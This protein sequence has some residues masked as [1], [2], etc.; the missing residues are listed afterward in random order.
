MKELALQRI[1]LGGSCHWCTEAIFRSL[2]GV[3]RVS[4]GWLS[5]AGDNCFSEG[6]VIE[7]DEQVID[8]QTV[9]EIHLHTHS[10]TSMHALRERYRSAVY[11]FEPAQKQAAQECLTTLQQEFEQPLITR[12]L[13]YQ[14]FEPSRVQIQDYYYSNPQKPFCINQITPKLQKLLET[15]SCRVEPGKRAVIEDG[16]KQKGRT[17]MAEEKDYT[18][19]HDREKHEYR[20]EV[21]PGVYA[22]VTYRE[23]DNVLHLTY[24][25][26]PSSMRGQGIGSILMD[27]VLSQ[28]QSE[29]YRVLPVCGFISNYIAEH[30]KWH[31]LLAD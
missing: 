27:K 29:G 23:E 16:I 2:N 25:E 5:S 18:V 13:D 1:G 20:M 10:C 12:V 21:S 3:T 24:S 22:L 26:V 9:I 6:I 17:A 11:V 28:I 7:Y 8:L 19:E 30:E 15:F 14:A 4:Q 31:P